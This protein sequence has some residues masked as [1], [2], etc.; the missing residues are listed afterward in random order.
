MSKSSEGLI[1]RPPSPAPLAQTVLI[2]QRA[3]TARLIEWE[4]GG[5]GAGVVGEFAAVMDVPVDQLCSLLG[6][7]PSTIARKRRLGGTLAPAVSQSVLRLAR[8]LDVARQLVENST[9]VDA[10]NFDPYK[11]LGR[12][13]WTAQPA[14]GGLRPATLIS[15]PTGAVAVERLL[16]AL[17]SGVYV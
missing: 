5:I 8:L 14:L 11:W 15:T 16:G 7:A 13:L 2:I 1:V 6:V 9:A 10:R 4:R 3:T 12:W 17:E